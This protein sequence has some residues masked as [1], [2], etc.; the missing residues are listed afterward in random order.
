LVKQVTDS[1]ECINCGNDGWL[2]VFSK[3]LSSFRSI[4][5]QEEF[6]DESELNLQDNLDLHAT[7]ATTAHVTQ[8][9]DLIYH[10]YRYSYPVND[11]YDE[12][13]FRKKIEDEHIIAL[14]VE[15]SEGAVIGNC[16][17]SFASSFVAEIGNL[18]TDPHYR[19]TVAV[20]LLVK[21][22]LQLLRDNTFKNTLFY[23]KLVT[24][25]TN[26][27]RLM[28]VCKFAPVGLQL[29]LFDGV[30]FLG[31]NENISQRESCVFA[32]LTTRFVGSNLTVY[33]P[34]EHQQIIDKLL[35]NTG[36]SITWPSEEVAATLPP[37]TRITNTPTSEILLM[38]TQVNEFGLDFTAI[39]KKETL[40][41]QQ[42]RFL[43]CILTF[44]LDKPLPSGIDQI[45]KDNKYFFS[46]LQLQK[47]GKWYLMYTNLFH[48]RFQFASME[49]HDPITRE[50]CNYMEKQYLSLY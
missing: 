39:L 32:V 47:D 50:L 25:H 13:I 35:T 45:L 7:R 27:Q 15:T 41:M 11:L 21:K 49:L 26:S 19:T 22:L 30:R 36:I 14:I 9:I 3:Q 6:L 29:S 20:T 1:F 2:M 46:G 16:M 12:Q 33:G 28:N 4:L 42:N 18:M 34:P 38:E 40:A 23:A 37:C 31:I 17:I 10:T 48:Q 8:L 43:T 24:T 5:Q 44:P